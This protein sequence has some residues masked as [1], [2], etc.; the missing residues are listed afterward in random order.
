MDRIVEVNIAIIVCSVIGVAKFLRMYAKGCTPLQSLRSKFFS[1]RN[2]FNSSEPYIRNNFGWPAAQ[3]ASPSAGR[4]TETAAHRS[5][6]ISLQNND[7]TYGY[8]DPRERWQIDPYLDTHG[9]EYSW[10]Y[11]RS[12]ELNVAVGITHPPEKALAWQSVNQG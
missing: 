4:D 10:M 9:P 5:I 2:S 8:V 6:P 12:P 11:K 3:E 1:F 7:T